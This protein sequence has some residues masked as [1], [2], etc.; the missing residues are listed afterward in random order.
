MTTTANPIDLSL[1]L[2]LDPD[3]CGGLAEMVSTATIAAQNGATVVQLRAP[4]WK[5]RQWLL[6]AQALKAALAP[7]NVPLIIN[8]QLD[9]A[10]AI[11]ADGVHVGQQDLPATEVRRLFGPNK[12]VGLSTNG[13]AQFHEAEGMYHAGIIDYV[14]VGPVYPTGT[15]KDAS[16]VIAVDEVAAMLQNRILPAVAI[17]GIQA[18]KVA[19]LM[20]LGFDGVA[21][22]SAICGQADVAGATQGLLAEI[23][24]AKGNT[25]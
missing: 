4:Q 12:I 16:P 15:K 23:H 24:A 3:L 21:V 2:V 10:L 8:D 7:Y 17:G 18:G 1:Y 9:I 14:G 19:H 25:K 20:A 22:V 13:L 11:D 6:A 5:K